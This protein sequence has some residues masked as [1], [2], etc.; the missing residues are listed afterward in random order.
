MLEG[1]GRLRLRSGRAR[2]CWGAGEAR[3]DMAPGVPVRNRLLAILLAEEA[4]LA[5][6]ALSSFCPADMLKKW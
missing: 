6:K 3:P 2:F 1:S 4:T 5:L